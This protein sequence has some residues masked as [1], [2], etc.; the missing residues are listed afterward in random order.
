MKRTLALLREKENHH[1]ENQSSPSMNRWF[2]EPI[3]NRTVVLQEARTRQE[4]RNTANCLRIAGYLRR[5]FH[6]REDIWKSFTNSKVLCISR[7]GTWWGK[8]SIS[9]GFWYASL[10]RSVVRAEQ[11]RG[12][13]SSR[14]LV[15]SKTMQRVLSGPSLGGARVA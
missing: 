8:P 3:T 15:L 9:V 7:R 5:V 1:E 2:V 6:A 11:T 12:C 14:L 13:V 4:A 10:D